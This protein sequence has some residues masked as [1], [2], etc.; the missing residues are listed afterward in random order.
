[1][2][3]LGHHV[4]LLT[5]KQNALVLNEEQV[6]NRYPEGSRLAR[7]DNYYRK[8]FLDAAKVVSPKDYD[9]LYVRFQL[10]IP[11]LYPALRRFKKSN[12]N[13]KIVVETPTFP[14]YGELKKWSD[15][16]M[17]W[18]DF[19]SKSKLR[20]VCDRI[21]T[22]CGQS[23]I[24]G[25]P[26]V[27]ISNGV[28]LQGVPFSPKKAYAPNEIHLVGVANV[29]NWHGY[30][31]VVAGLEAYYGQAQAVKVF[32]HMVGRGRASETLAQTVAQSRAKDYVVMYPN[33][34]GAALDDIFTKC[35]MG[36][37]S[38]GV[39][40]KLLDTAS[41]L[42]SRE[43]CARGKPFL[44][45]FHDDAFPVDAFPFAMHL[46][47]NDEPVDISAVVQFY[48]ALRDNHPDLEQKIRDY[49]TGSLS[50]SSQMARVPEIAQLR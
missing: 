16:V 7:Y 24:M 1:M 47:A 21:V 31:R 11:F 15:H 2:K 26:A 34:S 48:T 46:P 20:S 50:W 37:S 17:F 25:V 5:Y 40:R 10:G 14:Y 49:A 19:W 18:A 8:S 39:H 6:L 42:K 41:D 32:F 22:F 29:A 3:Q 13:L 12:P 35:D 4:D 27:S 9:L 38:L 44:V 33:M 36:V 23:Q 45:S 30:D 28:D 43:Y